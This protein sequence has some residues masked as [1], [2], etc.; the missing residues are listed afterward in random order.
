MSPLTFGNPRNKSR[1]ELYHREAGPKEG[2]IFDIGQHRI[3]AVGVHCDYSCCFYF[4][5]AKI[6]LIVLIAFALKSFA[7]VN[8]YELYDFYGT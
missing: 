8:S 7:N 2:D 5:Y 3:G 6:A 4:S 1:L